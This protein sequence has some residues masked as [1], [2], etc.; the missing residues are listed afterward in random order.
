M[1]RLLERVSGVSNR[2]LTVERA[3]PNA[4]NIVFL[5]HE[6][7]PSYVSYRISMAGLLLASHVHVPTHQGCIQKYKSMI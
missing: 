4:A 2:L 7:A 1:P 3:F 5:L 6:I